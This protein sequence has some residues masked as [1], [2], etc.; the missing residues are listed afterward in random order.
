MPGESRS[1]QRQAILARALSP[2]RGPSLAAFSVCNAICQTNT[3]TQDLMR[4]TTRR[5]GRNTADA[6]VRPASRVRAAPIRCTS[7][8]A[9]VTRKPSSPMG[10]F[11]GVGDVAEEVVPTATNRPRCRR[12][13]PPLPRISLPRGPNLNRKGFGFPIPSHIRRPPRHLPVL[14]SRAAQHGSPRPSRERLPPGL[15]QVAGPRPA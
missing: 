2:Q 15:A 11:Q 10:S 5:A 4:S 8:G 9:C 1:V 7:G 12:F 3:A 13:L 14:P 6:F